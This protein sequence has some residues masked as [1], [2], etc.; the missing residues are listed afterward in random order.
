LPDRRGPPV[1][2]GSY[3]WAL[4]AGRSGRWYPMSSVE[5]VPS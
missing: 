4:K 1:L 3:I 5:V 2:T